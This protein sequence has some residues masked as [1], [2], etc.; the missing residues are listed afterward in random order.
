MDLTNAAIANN[1][2]CMINVHYLLV[3]VKRPLHH[4][5]TFIRFDCP[6]IIL[7]SDLFALNN[8]R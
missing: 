1:R 3:C 5:S 2:A 7:F 6:E 8:H 4:L